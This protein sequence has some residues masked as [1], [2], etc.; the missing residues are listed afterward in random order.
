MKGASTS[1]ENEETLSPS[2]GTS[3]DSNSSVTMAM[4]NLSTD[5]TDVISMD[6]TN[7]GAVVT[8]EINVTGEASTTKNQTKD[9]PNP[10]LHYQ[11]KQI[12]PLLSGSSRLGRALAEL[13]ALLVKLCVGSPLRQRRGQM[14]PTPAPP[15]YVNYIEIYIHITFYFS[16]LTYEGYK[17]RFTSFL[18]R[19]LGT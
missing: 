3:A 9:K 15:R 14:P 12:K 18:V 13:F 10:V 5:P 19:Q 4:E 17:L 8:N 1:H 11:I 6:A 7:N 16:N 2:S